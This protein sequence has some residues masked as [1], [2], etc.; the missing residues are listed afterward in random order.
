M[1]R[2]VSRKT[3]VLIFSAVNCHIFQYL[4][5]KGSISGRDVTVLLVSMIR[6]GI[7]CEGGRTVR[8]KQARVRNVPPDLT[9]ENSAFCS[10]SV[11]VILSVNSG[12][13]LAFVME[14]KYVFCEVETDVLLNI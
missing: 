8:S 7:C 3:A 4:A 10:H 9:L 12:N 1:H 5:A 14:E 2:A 13:L 11:S 6:M